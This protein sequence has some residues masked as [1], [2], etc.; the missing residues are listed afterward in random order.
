MAYDV[1][2]VRCDFPIL[3]RLIHG[4]PLVYLDNGASA[5]KPLAVLERIDAMYRQHYANVHRGLHTLS[6]EAT[7]AYEAARQ[8]VAR[9][10]G[11]ASSNE[12][13]FTRSATEA[14][15]IVAR[16]LGARLEAGDEVVLS[17]MEHH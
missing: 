15:N 5:H 16:G 7:E 14:I 11:S 2:A 9:F 17:I 13:V 4:K 12:V 6:N 1:E 8:T 3:S 10:L